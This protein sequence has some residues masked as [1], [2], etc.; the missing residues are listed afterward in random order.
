MGHNLVLWNNEEELNILIGKDAMASG[1]I[2]VFTVSSH[3]Y[4]Y[5]L[6]MTM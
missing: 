3:F 1:C 5:E 4:K 2:T 6:Y